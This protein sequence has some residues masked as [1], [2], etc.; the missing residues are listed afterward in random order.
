MESN[1]L[2]RILNILSDLG[3]N[4][5]SN[6]K[7]EILKSNIND[8]QLQRVFKYAYDKDYK[9]GVS[10]S[11]LVKINKLIYD[12]IAYEDI[13][14]LLDLLRE[15]KLTGNAALEACNEFYSGS[16]WGELFKMILNHDLNDGIGVTTLKKVWPSMFSS[17][18]VALAEVWEDKMRKK[19]NLSKEQWFFSRKL[20]G[21]RCIAIKTGSIVKIY[22]RSGKEYLTLDVLKSE[23]SQL[24]GDFVLDGECCIVNE[25]GDENFTDIIKEIKRKN[26]TIKNPHYFIFDCLTLDEFESHTSTATLTERLARLSNINIDKVSHA[27]VLKQTQLISYEQFD[28]MIEEAA[29]KGWEGLIIRNNVGYEGKR[30]NN[31]LKVKK[32]LDAE[33]TVIAVHNDIL[34]WTENGRQIERECLSNIEIE[35]KGSIVSVGSGFSKD[36]RIYY[37]EHPDELIGATITVK[38]FQE[39]QNENGGWSLRFPTVKAIYPNGREL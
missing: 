35:H 21:I 36:Q 12:P 9:Y 16:P 27:E 19:V 20:D 17:F 34:K 24:P 13:F 30:S 18:G 37:Y 10:G 29:Q 4:S 32:F 33:Y 28:D 6:K 2:E 38:Y 26:H 14:Y 22:S 23:I 11:R 5:G 7:L 31:M 3:N 15:R 1:D 8:T 25:H 39:S